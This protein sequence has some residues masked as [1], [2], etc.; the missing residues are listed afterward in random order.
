MNKHRLSKQS[1]KRSLSYKWQLAKIGKEVLR[2]FNK[3]KGYYKN[4][5]VQ[6]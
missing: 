5:E 1:R 2:S 6:D 4:E 3:F